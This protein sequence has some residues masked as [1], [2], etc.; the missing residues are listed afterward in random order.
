MLNGFSNEYG[1]IK[2]VGRLSVATENKLR[3][4]R[5]VVR[6]YRVHNLITGGLSFKP[7]TVRAVC[8]VT[9]VAYAELT[10]VGAPIGYIY[11]ELILY[12][13]GNAH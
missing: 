5:E 1:I 9:V 12:D 3:E 2:T 13:I 6:E 8:T 11:V 7:K 10:T 4:D